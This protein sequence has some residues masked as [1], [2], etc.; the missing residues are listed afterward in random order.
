MAIWRRTRSERACNPDE[1]ERQSESSRNFLKALVDPR[2]PTLDIIAVHGLN[3]LDRQSHAAATWTAGE[4]LWLKDF[5]PKQAPGARILL[6]GY[7]ANVAFQTA[8]AGV[9]EQ[10]ENLLNQLEKAR[11]GDPGRPL[12]FICHSLGGIIAKRALVHAKSDKTYESIW[13]STFGITFFAT[14]HNGGNHAGIGDIV[15]KVACSILRSPGNNFMTALKKGSSF[16]DII[17][18]DFRQLLDDFQILSFYETKPLG[19][20]GIVV[21]QKSAVLGLPGVREKQIP[22]DANHSNICKFGSEQDPRY[23]QVADNIV[24]MINNASSCHSRTASSEPCLQGNI[25]KCEGDGNTTVQGGY[26]NHSNTNGSANKTYQFGDGNKSDNFGN[27]NTTTQIGI[28]SLDLDCCT[29]IL[30]LIEKLTG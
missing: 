29:G 23:I 1:Q 22:L 10:A 30:L 24:K 15:A 14:P 9:R 27:R 7:N 18:D 13:K 5:L 12:I 26:A 3:P 2:K 28:M 6:F 20:F 19:S 16:L 25:S 17:S 8:S 11:S 4:R 21:N